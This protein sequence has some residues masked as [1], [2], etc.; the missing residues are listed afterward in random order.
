MIAGIVIGVLLAIAAIIILPS[1]RKI[2]AKEIGLS[3]KR[4]GASLKQ[5]DP[6]AF[7]GE[8][9]YQAD[10][11]MP[12][13]RFKLWLLYSVTNHRWV[14]VPGDGI[15]VVISQVGKPLPP[16]AKS[17]P[18]N[19]DMETINDVHKFLNNGGGKGVQRNVLP[20]GTLAPIHPVA[21]IVMTYQ[22]IYGIP[23]SSGVFKS[24]TKSELAEGKTSLQSFGLTPEDFKLVKIGP[25]G[26]EELQA[27]VSRIDLID[28]GRAIRSSRQDIVD[29]IGI[30]TTLEGDPLQRAD[31]ASRLGGY[32]DILRL[33]S[34]SKQKGTD[35]DKTELAEMILMS[36]NDKHNNYQDFRKF[37]DIGG[38]IGLQHDPIL[39]GNYTLNPFLVGVE[40]VPMLLVEQGEVAVIKAYVG[41]VTQDTSGVDW[42]YGTLVNPGHKGIWEEALRTGKYAM[43]PRCYKAEIVPTA[44][45]T[46]NWSEAISEAHKLDE[47]L[48]SIEAKSIEGFVFK[49]DLQVQIHIPDTKASRV[50]SQV[51]TIDNLINEVLQAAVGNHFRDKLQSMK[52]VEFIQERQK[53]QE[54]AKTH[55]EEK[56]KVFEVETIGVFI[57]DVVFPENLVKVLTERE[58]ARQEI[59]TWQRKKE[60][61]DERILTEHS[62]GTADKQKEL[63]SAQVEVAIKTNWA[64]ARIKEGEGEASFVEQTGKA[65]GAQ[66]LA[67]GMAYAEAY[68]E[69]VAALGAGNTTAVNVAKDLA[70][71]NNKFMPD[72]LSL[73][74]GGSLENLL[75]A[76]TGSIT[77]GGNGKG[78]ETERL[79]I[80]ESNIKEVE[81]ETLDS[82]PESDPEEVR[83]QGP[84]EDPLEGQFSLE[85]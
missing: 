77:K 68:R 82:I 15:G 79:P 72:V 21:F 80:T 34:E 83:F 64:E 75:G 25:M 7:N 8:A 30:V 46:L 49:I 42:K 65:K 84:L 73:G 62:K 13:Y 9:G 45:L 52:A 4:I 16:G 40:I 19:V 47:R 60:A 54:E 55:I 66:V 43:N 74:Q 78:A 18:Y 70:N 85:E 1:I 17:S 61:E 35:V 63:A 33:E 57:Q 2:G 5:G 56:L 11:L 36:Q 41:E 39:Y 76:L 58:V 27:K 50:I 69:Q 31:I 20:P 10:L 67:V 3:N 28:E 14:Q 32:E 81:K 71:S 26:V 48:S 23:I 22:N 51:G 12:G 59:E 53:V 6:V 24:L 38:K 37:L 44:I 29:T